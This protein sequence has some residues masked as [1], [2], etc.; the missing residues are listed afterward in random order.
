M[1]DARSKKI[2]FF[3]FLLLTGWLQVNPIEVSGLVIQWNNGMKAGLQLGLLADHLCR[4]DHAVQYLVQ[5]H[6][7]TTLLT[8]GVSCCCTTKCSIELLLHHFWFS[9]IYLKRKIS[10]FRC[11]KGFKTNV[12]FCDIYNCESAAENTNT[13]LGMDI[14]AFSWL[15]KEGRCDVPFASQHI[16]DCSEYVGSCSP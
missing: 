8:R 15:F 16:T 13:A 12:M 14:D 6:I 1:V 3:S 9:F 7:G 10:F 4:G 2:R 5:L 11:K